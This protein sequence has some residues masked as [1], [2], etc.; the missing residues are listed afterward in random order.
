MF[1]VIVCWPMAT[2]LTSRS[3]SF[4]G[5]FSS[6][7]DLLSWLL[8]EQPKGWSYSAIQVWYTWMGIV[9]IWPQTKY[10]RVPFVQQTT[11]RM[12]QLAQQYQAAAG[13]LKLDNQ[14]NGGGSA[15]A[16]DVR[17]SVDAIAASLLR[18]QFSVLGQLA[19]LLCARTEPL[20][21]ILKEL[22]A[23]SEVAT[24]AL[25][26]LVGACE[27]LQV[28]YKDMARQQ[29]QLKRKKKQQQRSN[30]QVALNP[31]LLKLTVSTDHVERERESYARRGVRCPPA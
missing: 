6:A 13:E 14:Q 15:A 31:L 8:T 22:S 26:L 5:W 17:E 16:R 25:Q 12:L 20:Y 1:D 30:Q 23:S 28:Q 21:S 7:P 27:D 9:A 19:P 4:P 10:M 2:V 24:A 29:Q 3:C 18:G 11:P